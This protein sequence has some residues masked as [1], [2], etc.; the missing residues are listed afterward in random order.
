LPKDWYFRITE[1]IFVAKKKEAES[2]PTY[3]LPK[4]W[5]G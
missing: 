1:H 2:L 3:P 4:L 5:G